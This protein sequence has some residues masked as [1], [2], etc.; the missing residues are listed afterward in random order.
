MFQKK[1]IKIPD[2]YKDVHRGKELFP[3]VHFLHQGR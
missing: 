1:C 3:A 2:W